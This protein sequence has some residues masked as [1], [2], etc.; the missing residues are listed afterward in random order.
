MPR[1]RTVTPQVEALIASVYEKH[2]KWKAPTVRNEVLSILRA[3][4]RNCPEGWPSLSKVQKILATV[5]KNK[6]KP[7]PQDE[8]WSIN[9]LQ[10]YP[11]PPEALPKVLES[12]K[13]RLAEGTP[14]TVRE[15][16]WIARLSAIKSSKDLLGVTPQAKGP[17][18]LQVKLEFLPYQIAKT[19]QLYEL[20]GQPPK[21]EIYD[22]LLAG[23]PGRSADWQVPFMASASLA[24]ILKDD[25]TRK[26]KPKKRSTK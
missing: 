21:L 3:R 12:Y 15:A 10:D 22:R 1:R 8:P 25:P 23:L 14:L 4:D 26:N 7:N 13:A 24:G 20:L 6:E 11:I 16:K 18:T 2:P 9:T 5:R 17:P 19:E